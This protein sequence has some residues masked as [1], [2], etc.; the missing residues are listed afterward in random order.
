MIIRSDRWAN[1][2]KGWLNVKEIPVLVVG[3]ENL[4][5]DTY[6]ELKRMLNFIGYPYSEDDVLCSVKSSGESFH[7]N[8]KKR[9][10]NPYSP[11]LQEYVLGQIKTIDARL[12]EHDISLYHPYTI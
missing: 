9:L 5:K 1:Y 11:E 4:V 10:I 7:R 8:H 12:L 6:T 3:Y 2:V